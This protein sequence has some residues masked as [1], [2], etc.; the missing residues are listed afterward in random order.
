MEDIYLINSPIKLFIF[1]MLSALGM[2]AIIYFCAINFPE[3]R[4]SYLNLMCKAS[5]N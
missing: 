4:E 2:I 3:T 5:T 1:G